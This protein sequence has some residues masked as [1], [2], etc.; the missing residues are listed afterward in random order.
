MV[1]RDKIRRANRRKEKKR[2]K[3]NRDES[4]INIQTGTE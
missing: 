2:R 1:T 3:R 4:A